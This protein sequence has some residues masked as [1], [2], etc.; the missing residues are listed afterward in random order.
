MAPVADAPGTE[1]TSWLRRVR[2]KLLEQHTGTARLS[3]AVALGVFIA[4]TPFY[5]LHAPLALAVAWVLRLNIAATILATQVANPLCAP[6]LIAASAW[7]GNALGAG[8]PAL[9]R[10]WWD[11][12]TPGFYLDWL[13]GGMVLG[14][15]L[16]T[17]AG[18]ATFSALTWARR[19]R[20]V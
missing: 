8:D 1:R 17:I 15:G 19:R 10:D 11:P 18:A 14:L 5:G 16:G 4:L 3:V 12:T 9:D 7:V 20:H 6:L 2:A 13:R